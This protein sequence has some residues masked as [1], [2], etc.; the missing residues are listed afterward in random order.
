MKKPLR[1][2]AGIFSS[3]TLS[4]FALIPFAFSASAQEEHVSDIA[5][6]MAVYTGGELTAGNKGLGAT[7]QFGVNRGD[8]GVLGKL[9]GKNNFENYRARFFTPNKRTGTGLFVDAGHDFSNDEFTSNY[10]SAGVMQVFELSDKVKLYSALTYGKIWEE[11]QQFEDTQII[12][13]TNY[14]KY[15]FAPQ[16]YLQLAPQYVYGL[17]GEH[18]REFSTEMQLGYRVNDDNVIILSGDTDNNTWM[19]FRTRF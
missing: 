11:N 1:L 15:E 18:T 16:F 13:S 6:P 4:I 10:A 12:S 9:E 8:W 19:T 14:L 17:D 5:D 2:L 3:F 7:F